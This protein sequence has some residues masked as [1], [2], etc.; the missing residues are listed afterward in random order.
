MTIQHPARFAALL[1]V[2]IA[3]C[4]S[5]LPQKPAPIIDKTHPQAS[6]AEAH[7]AHTVVAP[8][9]LT[10]KPPAAKPVVVSAP[11]VDADPRPG[12]YVVKKGDTL[13]SIAL[14]NG[15]DYK[16]IA[17]W[18][19]LEDVNLIKIDQVLR[20][21]A[22]EGAISKPLAPVAS[23]ES[24]TIVEARDYPKALKLPYSPQAA[25]E[26]GKLANGPTPPVKPVV[27]TVKPEGRQENK[28][29]AEKTEPK[30]D[31]KTVENKE[32][33]SNV[34]GSDEI[35]DWAWP[36]N[37]KA[38]VS[39]SESSKGVDI[40]GKTG[41]AVFAAAAGK[42]VYAGSG[43]RG[44]GKLIII[45]HSKAYL[46]AYAHNNQLSVKEGESVKKGDK[47]AEMG[48]SDADQVKLH[49]E[50]RRYGK[51]VDPTRYIT[52]DKHE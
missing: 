18:N 32:K 19:Q 20:L 17:E 39:F 46:S 48:N 24:T 9:Q 22:P 6:K 49:F 2:L 51:P 27:A 34:T 30:T 16:E 47:I 8:P 28:P 42:V 29:V 33:P 23:V 52:A 41:Q 21:S 44:Y 38:M 37:G 25:S 7:P 43:L 50:I 11:V 45:K 36:T 35:S 13:Y 26:I 5:N 1:L 12:S 40:A 4:A 10:V 31:N 3:G 14:E 15:L